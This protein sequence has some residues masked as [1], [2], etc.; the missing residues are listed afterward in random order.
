ML[1][2]AD[3]VILPYD[4]QYSRAGVQ[5]A[6]DSLYFSARQGRPT[7]PSDLRRIVTG[8]GFEMATRRWL[9]AGSIRYDR[10]GATSLTSPD[11][12]EL[13]IGGRRC[14]LRFCL[15]GDKGRIASLHADPA[16]L[17]EA[18]ALV[19]DADLASE[20]L[21]ES[22]VYVFGFVTGLEARQSADSLKAAGRGLPVYMLHSPAPEVWACIDPWQSLGALAFK[23]NAE[24]PLRIEIGGQDGQ[25][26]L[27]RERVKLPPRTRMTALRDYYAL[28]YLG[29]PTLPAAAVGLH[30]A[31]RGQ[32]AIVEPVDWD[33]IWLYGQRVYLC[34]WLNKHDFREQS[35][36]LPAQTCIKQL[37]Q[38]T[39]DCHSLTVTGLRAMAELA[40]LATRH[41]RKTPIERSALPG[42]RGG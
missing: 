31:G 17:L 30:C 29:T 13:A 27:I 33:N 18:E 7:S 34:G 10:L 41:Q 38:T 42:A 8:I 21:E 22:D 4:E 26:K 2:P 5:Y 20:R 37:S 40:E 6:R 14:D 1:T 39:D 35:R 11:R 32:T 16:W 15:I 19:S 23:S 12:F 36:R 9:E 28:F 3:I 25:H 24:E